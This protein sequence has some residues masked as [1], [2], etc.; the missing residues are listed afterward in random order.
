MFWCETGG[1]TPRDYDALALFVAQLAAAGAPAVVDSRGVPDGLSRY[2]Q[3]ELAPYLREG[4][5][6]GRD[7]VVV[8]GAH[9]L[10]DGR[11]ARLRRLAGPSGRRVVALG[12]FETRQ[13]VTGV[14]ARLSYVFG[15]D[16]VTRESG[17]E[18]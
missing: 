7:T 5:P 3:F 12:A 14:K 11:L 1:E 17:E 16:P 10:T 18:G 2:V 15:Q 6:E 9:R 4:P 13:A 8:V